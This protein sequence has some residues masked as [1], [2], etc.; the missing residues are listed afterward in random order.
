MSAVVR[1]NCMVW[2][3]KRRI[4]L[5]RA[6]RAA[7]RPIGREPALRIRGSRLEPREIAGVKVPHFEVEYFD[8]AR[9]VR[10]GWAPLDKRPLPWCR[11][12][13]ALWTDGEIVKET[14]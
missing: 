2:A 3:I 6:H 13:R 1:S 10:E 5:G 9:W 11:L 14:L 4:E 12:W 7:G 8:G